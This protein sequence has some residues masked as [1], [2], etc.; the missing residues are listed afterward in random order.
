VP[1][2]GCESGL[3]DEQKNRKMLIDTRK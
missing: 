2:R 3:A 1:D